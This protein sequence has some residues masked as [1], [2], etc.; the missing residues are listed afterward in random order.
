MKPA[1]TLEFDNPWKDIIERQ[2]P[3]FTK[4]FFPRLAKKIDW[5]KP[6]EF[7]DQELSKVIR[8]AVN[9]SRRVDKLVKVWLL[10][11]T[12]TILYIHI[13]VQSQQQSSF[14]KRVFIYHYRLFDCYG[15]C[16]TSLVILGDDNPNWRPDRYQYQTPG[17]RLSFRFTSV[18]LWDYLNK[19][20]RLEKSR[21]PF[22]LV[23][24]THLLGL[25]TR[26]SPTRRLDG[27]KALLQ[28]LYDSN[29]PE[30][31]FFDLYVFLDWVLTLPDHL[32]T[33]FEYF[34]ATC[35]E[36]KKMQ[37]V[38]HIERR[39]IQQ[40]LQ[41]GLEQG[42][43]QKSREAVNDVLK[44]RFH[45]VPKALIDQINALSDTLRL[46]ALLKEAIVID[47]LAAFEQR[48]AQPTKTTTTKRATTSRR[49]Q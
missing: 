15:P 13:E 24:R 1:S 44:V 31:L 25:Q 45:R 48:L 37:Y 16:V 36:T 3:D 12:E 18:K 43:L 17:S 28:A 41:Q 40:G 2:F 38:T 39:G 5:H 47:S 9:K 27:K 29:L 30:P 20:E 46:S 4:F 10:D 21:N 34:V 23:V 8:T 26:H 14:P 32:E 22:A 35:E 6:I 11:G 7:L 19:M 42:Q 33:Q 49:H